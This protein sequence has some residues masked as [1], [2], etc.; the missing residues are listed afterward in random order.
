MS[1]LLN[2]QQLVLVDKINYK[3]NK[4]ILK[5]NLLHLYLLIVFIFLLNSKRL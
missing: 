1:T 4:S 3:E 2:R 5:S